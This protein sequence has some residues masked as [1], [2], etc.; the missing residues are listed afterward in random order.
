M[1]QQTLL[2]DDNAGVS[3][4]MRSKEESHDYRYFPE[5]DLVRLRVDKSWVEE[6][7][8]SLAELPAARRDRFVKDYGIP[9]YDAEVLTL[10]KS[11]A[12]YYEETLKVV[13]DGKLASNWIMSEMMAV[14]KERKQDADEFIVKPAQL[15]ALLNM[16]VNQAISGKIAKTVF[17]EM[18]RSGED[19]EVIVEKKGLVQITNRS[20]I[21]KIVD[22]MFEENQTQLKDYLSGKQAL[23]GHFVGQVMKLSHG[24][25]NPAITNEVLKEKLAN[26]K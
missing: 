22:Q 16:V 18:C 20:E 3:K 19:P 4:P 10:T 17:E 11:L 7:A 14:L 25:A 1:I 9:K 24:K 2:W 15:G 12:N 21:E 5:P 6:I 8:S 13:K 26:M 23:F